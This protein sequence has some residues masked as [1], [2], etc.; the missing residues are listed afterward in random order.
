MQ[1]GT[2]G[3]KILKSSLSPLIIVI[4]I[5]ILHFIYSFRLKPIL[6]EE[7]TKV[8]SKGFF[9]ILALVIVFFFQRIMSSVFAWY[10]QNIAI[11]TE[12]RFV[13]EILPLLKRI[14]NIIIWIIALLVIL[15]NFGIN[16]NA[17]VATLGVSSLAIALAA[18]DTIANIISGFLIMIDRPFRIGDEIKLPSGEKVRVLDIGI[19][20][21]RFINLEDKA[22]IIVPNLELSKSK[23]V[24]FTYGKEREEA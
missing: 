8:I 11:K 19:R 20:R 3:L 18:Q 16:I 9:A 23:I 14:T 17:L 7:I 24:N 15:S 4:L 2:L 22:V 12:R 1:K 10:S 13:S 5:L 6:S 21:S